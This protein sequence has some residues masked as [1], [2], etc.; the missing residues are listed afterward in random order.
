[1]SEW[2]IGLTLDE[3]VCTVGDIV[4]NGCAS[5]AWSTSPGDNVRGIDEMGAVVG[6]AN[7]AIG[8][9]GVA[10]GDIKNGRCQAVAVGDEHG[11]SIVDSGADRCWSGVN[12]GGILVSAIGENCS[13]RCT[14]KCPTVGVDGIMGAGSGLWTPVPGG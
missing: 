11:G 3:F 5:N 10:V 12:G 6:V 13:D 2:N 4:G 8:V 1:M 9:V 7:G 14:G